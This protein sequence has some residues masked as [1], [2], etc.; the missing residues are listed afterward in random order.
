MASTR[1][2][3]G[4]TGSRRFSAR[5]ASPSGSSSATSGCCSS[6]PASTA[7]SPSTSSPAL[8]GARPSPAEITDVV[9][10]A[11]RRRPL[12]RQLGAAPRGATCTDPRLGGRS[13]VDRVVGGDLP[14]ALRL[15][16]RLRARLRRGDLAAGWRRRPGP[17][18]R[19]TARSP[20]ERRIDLGGIAVEVVAL[21]R[22]FARSPGCRCTTSRATAIVMDAVLERGLYTTVDD[23]LISPPP[24]GSVAAYRGTVERLRT[25]APGPARHEPL[26]A[27]RGARRR[28]TAFLDATAAF[29]DDLDA[30]RP[31]RARTR[32]ATRSSTT[33]A[34][35][36]PRSARSARWRSSSPARWPPTSTTPST[37]G[38]A[39]RRT[40]RARRAG[41]GAPPEVGCHIAA[42]GHSRSLANFDQRSRLTYSVI[43]CHIWHRWHARARLTVDRPCRPDP[44][45]ARSRA[46]RWS[47]STA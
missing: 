47:R 10:I 11:R 12:R 23:E 7:R 28:S 46:T 37:K 20:T 31:R 2:S 15:V 29:V 4:S 24:Y 1:C 34:P 13:A 41:L 8:R 32:A 18:R 39:P 16:S 40:T 27:D 36:T 14:R 35:R 30:V 22:P 33:G 9:I 45:P 17:T 26:R 6:T 25:L 38:R 19:S 43:W 42:P 3:R 5:A 21:A 44:R